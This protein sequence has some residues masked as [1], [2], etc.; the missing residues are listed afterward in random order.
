MPC[1]SPLTAYRDACGK[2]TFSKGEVAGYGSGSYSTLRCGMC[3]DCRLHK[4]REWAIR[5]YHESTMC[6]RSCFITLTY[7]ADPGSISKR[8]LQLFFKRLR[9]AIRKRIS[10]FACGE[11]G[12][13]LGRPHYHVCLF[14][15]DFPLKYP[16]NKSPKGYTQFRD[17]LLERLW[18]HGFATIG[19]L[20]M[21][22]AGYAARYSM[23]KI[24]GDESTDHYKRLFEGKE[25]NVQPE[26]QLSS[27]RP[28]IGHRWISEYWP[29]VAKG[30]SVI[31]QGKECPVP[32]YYNRYI[33]REHPD[34][35][36][37]MQKSW[38]QYRSRHPHESG[39][40][41][42]QAAKARD[43]KTKRLVREYEQR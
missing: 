5:C 4:A 31:Y 37:D 15:Y 25:I 14:G 16:W 22:S 19:Q 1:R 12:E 7:Q 43:A 11:Y 38:D 40:R 3:R 24:T 17:E 41:M 13:K 36:K 10:Y 28:A 8:D 32:Q 33:A 21:E 20:T 18:P 2:I 23:K 29:E 35:Y 26:F 39:V 42:Y 30:G 34:A 6:E 27:T 9:K